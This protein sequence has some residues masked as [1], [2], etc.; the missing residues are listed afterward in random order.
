[1]L[2]NALLMSSG[3]QGENTE[4]FQFWVKEQ[5]VLVDILN[6]QHKEPTLSSLHIL[7]LTVSLLYQLSKQPFYFV[8][9]E[10]N[11]MAELDSLLMNLIP[12]Y[13]VPKDWASVVKPS[14][15]TEYDWPMATAS[16][17]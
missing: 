16:G 9:L 3:G 14:K 1:M 4:Q 13:C 17:M 2:I 12:K 10:N 8:D 15:L 11:G 7:H 6:D 5:S